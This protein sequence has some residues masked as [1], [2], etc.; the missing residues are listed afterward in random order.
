MI[1]LHFHE[2]SLPT[3]TIKRRYASCS[4]V[5]GFNILVLKPC[6]KMRWV[7]N[8]EVFRLARFLT[9]LNAVNRL[10]FGANTVYFTFV[11]FWLVCNGPRYDEGPKNWQNLFAISNISRFCLFHLFYY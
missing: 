4:L 5:L 3:R 2:Y 1:I 9:D 10:L 6:K 7:F 8:L 11:M